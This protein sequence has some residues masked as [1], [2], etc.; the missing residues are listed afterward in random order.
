M[1]RIAVFERTLTPVDSGSHVSRG[2]VSIVFAFSPNEVVTSVVL[3]LVAK[4]FATVLAKLASS[5][6][7]AANCVSVCRAMGAPSNNVLT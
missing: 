3:A 5:F 7:A 1:V 2:C 6:S 4:V